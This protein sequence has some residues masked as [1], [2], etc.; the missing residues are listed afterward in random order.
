MQR[1]LL[2]ADEA[3]S[4]EELATWFRGS[5]R[6]AEAM[7]EETIQ[8]LSHR[9]LIALLVSVLDHAF[10]DLIKSWNTAEEFLELDRGSG[11]LFYSPSDELVRL[12][13]E[14]PM[15]PVLGFQ[16]HDPENSGEGELRFFHVRGMGR[17][18][19][20]HLN[21]GLQISEGVAGPHVVLT[22]GTSWAPTSWRYHLHVPPATILEP[23]S[24]E[25]PDVSCFFEPLADPEHPQRRLY[26]SGRK[27]AS[28]RVRSLKSMVSD[29][30]RPTGFGAQRMSKFDRELAL[31]DEHRRRILLV[32]GSY[33]EAE[34]VGEALA[35]ALKSA[36]G[37]DVLT[38][39]PDGGD[40]PV[41]DRPQDRLLRSQVSQ[42]PHKSAR[43]LVAPLQAM[44]RGH[45]ILVGQEGAI[46]SVYFLVR[47]FPRPGDPHAAI[48]RMNAWAAEYVPTLTSLNA[49]E[50]GQQLREE[51][52]AR[53]KRDL[54][55]EETYKGT[56]DKTPLLWT[57]LVLVWQCIGRL[58]R[59]GAA[60]RV[61][62]I[63]AKWA[64]VTTG[65]TAGPFDTEDSSMLI[66]FQ[67]VLTDVTN[68]AEPTER[69]IAQAL[70][71]PF[72]DGLVAMKGIHR[73]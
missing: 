12:V 53:W 50:A 37:E 34:A 35:D 18:L 68:S 47:P 5:F 49:G 30:A 24:A 41:K 71:G 2:A 21:D 27:S 11:G 61:H 73:E 1:E 6:F 23:A 7:E 67:R 16:Y 19:L 64:E 10:R 3:A 60:A 72:L 69:L 28:E 29:L 51:A 46:G 65:L 58:L 20:Y 54:Q 57:Q 17:A 33:A 63:D 15:G 48:Q 39:I 56:A 59:G 36:P 45:N 62:F 26:V 42:F 22:S 40:D 66:G 43:F 38:L 44:E 55:G 70:Y 25:Q 4:L 31:L 14:A 9:L 13:P 32:V 52:Y 8:E